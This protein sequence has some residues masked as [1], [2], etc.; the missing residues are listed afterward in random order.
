[1]FEFLCKHSG[2]ATL[3][4]FYVGIIL[5]SIKF[6]VLL[7]ICRSCQCF[8]SISSSTSTLSKSSRS[9]EWW[10]SG[11]DDEGQNK[12]RTACKRYV[13][14]EEDSLGGCVKYRIEGSIIRDSDW[15]QEIFRSA[16]G[17]QS[18]KVW[19]AKPLSKDYTSVKNIDLKTDLQLFF[20]SWCIVNSLGSK[21]G[22]QPEQ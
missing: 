13:L 7:V 2:L 19:R 14:R 10:S 21:C 6:F 12:I 4:I 18:R 15:N 3:D 9:I 8:W 1:M 11:L 20:I 5:T 17:F 22:I 16:L